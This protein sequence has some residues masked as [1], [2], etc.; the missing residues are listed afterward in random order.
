MSISV[1]GAIIFSLQDFVEIGMK[2]LTQWLASTYILRL[3]LLSLLCY[4]HDGE[5]FLLCVCV[6]VR[7][8]SPSLDSQSS[9]ILVKS[10]GAF[11]DSLY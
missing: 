9:Y 4:Y 3:L 5:L 2:C 6:C 10:E 1:Q 7:F 8:P 11:N